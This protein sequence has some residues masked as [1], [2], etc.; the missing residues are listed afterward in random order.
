MWE[1]QCRKNLPNSRWIDFDRY[2]EVM[3]TEIKSTLLVERPEK[4]RIY[5]KPTIDGFLFVYGLNR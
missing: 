2:R 3:G 5:R 1:R 4:S